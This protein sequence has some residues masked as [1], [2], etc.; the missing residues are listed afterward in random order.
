[1]KP[2][3]RG[4]QEFGA[5]LR[6]LR[7]DARL[8]GTELA[9]RLGWQSSKV[10]KIEHGKQTA[11]VDDVTAWAREVG[12]S[13]E[14]LT[15]LLAD[16]RAVRVE[17]RTWARL[18]KRGTA[19]RQRAV[20]PLDAA[21]SLLRAFEPAVVPGLLQ[22]AEY[23]RYVLQS[24][25]ELRGFPDD[26]AESVRARM[27]RQAILYDQEKQFRFLVTE[28]ALRYLVCPPV[29]LRGQLDRLLAVA[30][31]PNIEL[32]VIPTAVQLPFPAMHGFWIY[33]DKLVLVDTVSAELVLKD[34]DDI[35]LY[36]RLFERLWEIAVRGDEARRVT[37]EALEGLV[38]SGQPHQ[39]QERMS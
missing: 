8:T 24:V 33:D 15:D 9:A 20:A 16:L 23:A 12:G 21:T 35:E 34:R 27:E 36:V 22:T 11:S 38:E 13:A 19:V 28:A 37:V 2:I 10:S 4:R 14:L 29:V 7:E 39:P 31:L 1:L 32:A 6:T 18:V 26:V 3:P 30:S 25:V 5:R 17:Y